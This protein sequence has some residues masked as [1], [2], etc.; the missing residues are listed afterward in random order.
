M[1]KAVLAGLLVVALGL[2]WTNRASVVDAYRSGEETT[3]LRLGGVDLD[4]ASTAIEPS[5]YR[6]PA[7]PDSSAPAQPVVLGLGAEPPEIDEPTLAGGEARLIGTVVGPDGPVSGAVVRIERHGDQ[8]VATMDAITGDDGGWA[9]AP[10][11]GGRYR[12]RAWLPGLLTMGRSEVRFVAEDELATFDFSLWGIDPTPVIELVD[13]GPLY[14]GLA[15][16]VAL[17]AGWRSVDADGLV[18]TNPLVGAPITVESTAQVEVLSAQPLL[19]DASGVAL[20]Q[21]R[22]VPTP[23]VDASAPGAGGS[24]TARL[25]TIESTFVLPGC[26]PV[27][28]PDPQPDGGPDPDSDQ[29]AV[30]SPGPANDPPTGP[31]PEADLDG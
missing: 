9:I 23:S 25:G 1:V 17:V 5:P 10:L 24:L 26:R 16:P 21:L 13:G 30:P 19:T 6:R 15:S 31:D 18:V 28:E 3:P 14:E 22:C 8:G 2:M 20:V 11:A 4:V 29:P 7:A 27:P 12:V